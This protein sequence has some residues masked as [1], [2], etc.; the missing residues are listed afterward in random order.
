VAVDASTVAGSGTLVYQ[1]DMTAGVVTVSPVDI[2]STAGQATF[3]SGMAVGTKVKV[4]GVPQPD[5]SVKAYVITYF[6]GT[7]PAT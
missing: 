6:T 4:S 5:G 1:V 3:S 2:T 7:A